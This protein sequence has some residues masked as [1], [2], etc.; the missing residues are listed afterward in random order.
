MNVAIDA[1]L[2]RHP[3][4]GVQRYIVGLIR[5]IAAYVPGVNITAYLGRD[6]NGISEETECLRIC[7]AQVRNSW[8]PIRMLWEQFVLPFRLR[9]DGADLLHAP[10]YVMPALAPVVARIPTVLTVHDV[11]AL[12]RPHLVSLPN[13]LHYGLAM[14]LSIRLAR[15]VI[16]PTRAVADRISENA[17]AARCVEIVPWGIDEDVFSRRPSPADPDVLSRLGVAR[18]YVLHV[19]RLEPKKNIGQVVKAFFAMKMDTGLPHRLV[20]AGS[21]GPSYRSLLGLVR[22]LAMEEGIIF[23]GHVPDGDLAALYRQADLVLCAS[24]EEGFGFP[25]L[26]ALSCGTAVVTS[27][28]PAFAETLG[29]DVPVFDP[30]DLP[31]LR[32]I[33]TDMLK[34]ESARKDVVKAGGKRV[35]RYTWRR[36]AERTCEIYRECAGE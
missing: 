23:A 4:T 6:G 14:P 34:D 35:S 28:I 15:C 24:T 20:L 3:Y 31:A 7:R 19:G 27:N 17:L 32:K 10:G 21:P 11:T 18:P 26:E 12:D 22:E 9:V 16:V 5:A 36:C 8:R 2:L 29:G 33:M 30:S 25:S 1:M 13:G